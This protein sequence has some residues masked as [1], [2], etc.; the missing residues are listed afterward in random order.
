MQGGHDRAVVPGAVQGLL[1]G[2]HLGVLG[3][4]GTKASTEEANDS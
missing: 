4:G 3:R 1:D 2:Q